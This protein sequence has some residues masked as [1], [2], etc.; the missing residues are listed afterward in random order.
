MSALMIN[1]YWS[2]WMNQAQVLQTALPT[3]GTGAGISVQT[4][5]LAPPL[6]DLIA[7]SMAGKL[8]T[9]ALQLA[10]YSSNGQPLTLVKLVSRIQQIDLPAVDASNTGPVLVGVKFAQA[11]F[12]SGKP[13]TFPPANPKVQ[14]LRSSNF[15][16]QFDSLDA[17][18]AISIAGMSVV[19]PDV[20]KGGGLPQLVLRYSATTGSAQT[21]IKGLQQWFQSQTS[22]NG[23]LTFLDTD[24]RTPIL[25]VRYRGL[26]VV[27]NSVGT[28][29]PTATFT[30]TGINL[31]T[32]ATP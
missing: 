19:L 26:R 11:P 22:R 6:L 28:A 29:T 17:T 31:Q 1:T 21:F 32:G 24:L 9:P 2:G 10:T 30:M 20:M 27:S 12:E 14:V 8:S 4:S 13:T 3:G 18:T 25:I 15:H 7:Q 16:L 5:Y 23:T